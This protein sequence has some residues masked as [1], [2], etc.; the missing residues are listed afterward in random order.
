MKRIY[1]WLLVKLGLVERRC[2]WCRK[3]LGWKRIAWAAGGE[4][5]GMCKRCAENFNVEVVAP[6]VPS[7]PVRR[8]HQRRNKATLRRQIGGW[9]GA[10]AAR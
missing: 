4:T 2:G 8:F 6:L 7:K 9:S 10:V 5:T 3:F 1:K